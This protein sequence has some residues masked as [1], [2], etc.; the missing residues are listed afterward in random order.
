MRPSSIL[1]PCSRPNTVAGFAVS[2]TRS[3]KFLPGMVEFA[4]GLSQDELDRVAAATT[5][6]EVGNGSAFWNTSLYS[7]A[8]SSTQNGHDQG[9]ASRGVI[10]RDTQRNAIRDSWTRASYS[11]HDEAIL[12]SKP[13]ARLTHTELALIWSPRSAEEQE[14]SIEIFPDPPTRPPSCACRTHIK[15]AK[16][17]LGRRVRFADSTGKPQAE[18]FPI[19]TSSHSAMEDSI[20]KGTSGCG[21]VEGGGVYSGSSDC[22]MNWRGHCRPGLTQAELDTLCVHKSGQE[23]Y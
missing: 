12:N 3:T 10:L 19:C 15:P 7:D 1:L 16:M 23:D 20:F 2:A 13:L 21:G 5:D 11:G 18:V 17:K 22:S 9:V 14:H 6:I 8:V 4:S